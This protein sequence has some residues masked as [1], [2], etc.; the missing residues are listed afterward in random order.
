MREALMNVLRAGLCPEPKTLKGWEMR[1]SHVDEV[2][3]QALK[4]VEGRH[5][6]DT[7]CMV[8]PDGCCVV[9]GVEHGEPCPACGGRGFH[10]A[11]CGRSD[12]EV[13]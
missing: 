9:C 13:L 2:V 7:D 1:C 8:G 4:T 12:A 6:Q 3:R 10:A 5:S 11:G